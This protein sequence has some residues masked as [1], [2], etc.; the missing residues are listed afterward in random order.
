MC[1]VIP[2]VNDRERERKCVRER[3]RGKERDRGTE[4]EKGGNEGKGENVTV[5]REKTRKQRRPCTPR[6]RLLTLDI[7]PSATAFTQRV[8]TVRPKV[9][10]NARTII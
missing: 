4:R 5:K 1:V 7:C 2:Y 9:E 8:A 6:S 10:A 3:K